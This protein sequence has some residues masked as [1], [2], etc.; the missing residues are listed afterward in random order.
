MNTKVIP[1]SPMIKGRKQNANDVAKD[2][3]SIIAQHSTEGWEFYNFYTMET[4]I[5]GSSG[6]FGIGATPST[7][8]NLGFV[9]F[10]KK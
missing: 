1:F 6:C 10:K 5:A 9:V 8:M 4:M 2:L 3:E 7:M